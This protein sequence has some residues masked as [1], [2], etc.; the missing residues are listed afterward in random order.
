MRRLRS[1]VSL[2]LYF[3]LC[4]T[5]FAQDPVARPAPRVLFDFE[6]GKVQDGFV[7]TS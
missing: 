4:A 1:P 2:G 7:L 6:T 5:G 3:T